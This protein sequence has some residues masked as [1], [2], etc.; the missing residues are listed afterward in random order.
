[1]SEVK[2]STNDLFPYTEFKYS[3]AEKVTAY[4]GIISPHFLYI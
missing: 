1:M 2:M 3:I 4:P